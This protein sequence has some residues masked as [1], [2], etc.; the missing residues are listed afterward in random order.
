MTSRKLPK[1]S[2]TKLCWK[3]IKQ[4]KIPGV[5]SFMVQH[6]LRALCD[7]ISRFMSYQVIFPCVESRQALYSTRLKSNWHNNVVKTIYEVTS[8]FTFKYVITRSE[9]TCRRLKENYSGILC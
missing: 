9:F 7:E 6:G 3:K 1:K 5:Y 4:G 8:N 2:T